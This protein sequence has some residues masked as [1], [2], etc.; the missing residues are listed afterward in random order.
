MCQLIA[1]VDSGEEDAWVS[2]AIG[3]AREHFPSPLGG[4]GQ[5]MKSACS[6]K[7]DDARQESRGLTDDSRIWRSRTFLCVVVDEGTGDECVGRVSSGIARAVWGQS[8]LAMR[9]R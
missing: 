4:L 8:G 6:F 5:C 9:T 1:G 3:L 2:V 7:G